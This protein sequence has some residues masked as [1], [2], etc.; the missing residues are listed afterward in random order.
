MGASIS[1]KPLPSVTLGDDVRVETSET[2]EG[3]AEFRAGVLPGVVRWLSDWGV[4]TIPLVAA[5]RSNCERPDSEEFGL[6]LCTS[7]CPLTESATTLPLEC[8][9]E[10]E[11][12]GAAGGRAAP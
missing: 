1:R 5:P 10:F 12:L 4:G 7:F 2:L 6:D 8:G 9:L 11:G 3:A